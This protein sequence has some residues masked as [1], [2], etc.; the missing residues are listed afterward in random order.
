[1]QEL[2]R[3]ETSELQDARITA[4]VQGGLIAPNPADAVG[5]NRSRNLHSVL[6]E[7]E[8]L[9]TASLQAQADWLGLPCI[10]ALSDL[11]SGC[12]MT[13]QV[14][15]EMEW[16]MQQRQGWMDEDHRSDVLER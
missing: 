6:R 14:A 15:R 5:I 11:L 13:D 9:G 16:S 10:A 1:M 2:I 8:S 4:F 7:V 12:R 3:E